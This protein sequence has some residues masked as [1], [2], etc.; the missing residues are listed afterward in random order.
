MKKIG[1]LL[2]SVLV[3]FSCEQDELGD[4]MKSDVKQVQTRA[5][6][7]IA[8]FNPISELDGI[9]VNVINMGNSTR[10]FLS[11]PKSGNSVGLT[12]VDDNSGR[13]QWYIK[14]GKSIV[15]TKGNDAISTGNYLVAATDNWY[16]AAVPK[17]PN[18]IRL[19][20]VV[21]DDSPMGSLGLPGFMFN[22]LG[23]GNFQI[24]TGNGAFPPTSYYLNSE[25][26]TSS[27]LK[28]RTDNSTTLS[29]WQFVPVGEYE[30][31]DLKYVMT[32]VDN[33]TPTELICDRDSYDNPSSG[34]ATW[35]YSVSVKYTE[36]S[37]FS[38]TEGVSVSVS[39]GLNVGLPSASGNPSIGINTTIQQQAS[40][41]WTYG[42]SDTKEITK[43][44]TAN[45][46]VPPHTNIRLEAVLFLYEG[47]VTYV[48]TL[49]KIGDTKTFKVKGKWRGTSFSEFKAKTYDAST[50][51]LLNTSNFNE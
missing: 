19:F 51:K 20:S 29:Q 50:G 15:L 40:K 43:S 33:F 18:T 23:N 28:F 26:S 45:I 2:I 14:Y 8:D 49:R 46:Q 35:N 27:T 21:R 42:T 16:S 32:S 7:S 48:A 41:S 5:A 24:Q 34:V 36:T 25:S 37:N 10:K 31:V 12:T 3:L 1:L 38:K 47:T 44:R 30:L 4:F 13:Q 9:P 39:N 11:C 17:I 6:I 22:I